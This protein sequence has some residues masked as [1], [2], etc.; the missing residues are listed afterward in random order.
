MPSPKRSRISCDVAVI[1]GGIAALWC[2]RLA[3]ASGL[4]VVLLTDAVGGS[5]TLA[6]QGIIHSGYKYRGVSADAMR[7]MPA[8]WRTLLEGTGAF[9]LSD[10]ELIAPHMTVID[11]GSGERTQLDEPVVDVHSLVASLRRPLAPVT[12]RTLVGADDIVATDQTVET[13]RTPIADVSAQRYLICAGSGND[14]IAAALGAS[15]PTV[16]R[17]LRQVIARSPSSIE[18][19]F[20]HVFEREPDPAVTVT[21]HTIDAVTYL[22]F[23]GRV[24][25]ENIDAQNFLASAREEIARLLPELALEGLV[26]STIRRD[27]A[28]LQ[29][30]DTR[31]LDVQVKRVANV[32]FC[33]PTKLCLVPRL[34]EKLADVWPLGAAGEP[35]SLEGAA[36]L[37]PSPLSSA[38]SRS[39]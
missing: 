4:S 23:G 1:G 14:S 5:Q 18:P 35:I 27:R 39:P 31:P 30:D 13:I 38:F 11:T 7:A 20:C 12:I 21:T 29:A 34:A 8:C 9:D 15:I 16:I 32:T 36:P 26:W 28:E 19:I 37:D 3:Q 10:V 6:A 24:A 33:W 2:A 17:P 22:Y 25:T